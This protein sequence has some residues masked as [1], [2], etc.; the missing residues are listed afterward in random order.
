MDADSVKYSGL[1][2]AANGAEY[3]R[4]LAVSCRS[5]FSFWP[6]F[7]K[8]LNWLCKMCVCVFYFSLHICWNILMLFKVTKTNSG[9]KKNQLLLPFQ[10][11]AR[12]LALGQLKMS[13]F[14]F[15]I[16]WL[17]CKTHR[18]VC[19]KCTEGNG[20]CIMN[21]FEDGLWYAKTTDTIKKEMDG[22]CVTSP[23]GF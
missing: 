16:R 21:I 2:T 19:R 20:L 7:R 15:S 6:Q 11:S 14:S 13:F 18:C 23:T 17:E 22:V 12:T 1:H 4:W 8:G 3:V 5:A 9:G 10:P